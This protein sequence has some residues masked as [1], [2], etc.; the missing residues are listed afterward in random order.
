[1]PSPS[2]MV[3][4]PTYN[5]FEF[6]KQ[7]VESLL[8]T[9]KDCRVSLIDDASRDY[10]KQKWDQWPLKH[11]DRLHYEKNKGLTRSWNQG[12]RNAAGLGAKYT[13][14]ANSDILFTPGW[15]E[16]M[17]W[18]LDNGADLVGPLTNAPGHQPKQQVNRYHPG[19]K[20]T[21][22]REYLAEVAKDLAAKNRKTFVP[23]RVNGFC[24]LAKT[25][26]WWA[27]AFNSGNVFN[28]KFRMTK[29]EDELQGRWGK[30]GMVSAIVPSAF[31][32]HFRGVS[33]KG[34][35]KGREGEGWFRASK[36]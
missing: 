36:K 33:R 28:P 24:M 13:C 7:A 29:N 18:A 8:D 19:F 16:A 35:T 2:L 6:A 11:M 14:C 9:T 17:S 31:V 27:N 22:D 10:G 12:L 4:I 1:M 26:T 5:H 15:F 3:I 25:D 34:A 23:S 21:D 20:L 32:F 30:R